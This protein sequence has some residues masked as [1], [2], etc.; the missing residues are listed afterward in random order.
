MITAPSPTRRWR[1]LPD[2]KRSR[3]SRSSSTMTGGP[4][5]LA[6]TRFL[7]KN[8]V[9]VATPFGRTSAS[10]P[11]PGHSG[12]IFRV[13]RPT[14]EALRQVFPLI[15][16]RRWQIPGDFSPKIRRSRPPVR[17]PGPESTRRSPLGR[18]FWR[19]IRRK[20]RSAGFG[21]PP[22]GPYRD[23]RPTK[24]KKSGPNG[25]WDAIFLRGTLTRPQNRHHS[26]PKEPPFER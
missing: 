4:V 7:A 13:S 20:S 26:S 1:S 3:D 22:V 15:V 12:L 10:G 8:L 9:P 6:R 18:D 14:R 19:K 24:K 2:Q 5:P 23:Y 25:H 17:H 11:F 16:P 21:A